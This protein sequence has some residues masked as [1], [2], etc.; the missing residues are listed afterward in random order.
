MIPDF[1]L[2]LSDEVLQIRRCGF[3]GVFV[4]FGFTWLFKEKLATPKYLAK[5]S[6]LPL[7]PLPIIS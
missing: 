2:N 3:S 1:L 7:H 5:Q 6:V 4:D